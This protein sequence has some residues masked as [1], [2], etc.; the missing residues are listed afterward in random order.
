MENKPLCKR[1]GKPLVAIG[2]SRRN[3]KPHRDWKTREYHK[4]CWLNL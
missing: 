1:C 2:N 4:K 3:G